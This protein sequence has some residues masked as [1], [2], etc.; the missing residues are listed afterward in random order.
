M[1]RRHLLNRL[2]LGTVGASVASACSNATQVFTPTSDRGGSSA[3][4]KWHMA[5]SWPEHLDIVSGTAQRLG[6]RVRELT[7]DNFLITAFPAG[8]ITPPLELIEG[9][10]QAATDRYG[11]SAGRDAPFWQVYDNWNSFRTGIDRWNSVNER[12]FADLIFSG[13]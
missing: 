8:G 3:R 5:T 6:D 9:V 7:W 13:S 10:H 4:I 2:A 12:S 1:K 11:E